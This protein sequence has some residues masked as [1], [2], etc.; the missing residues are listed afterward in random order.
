MNG[1]R[2]I[3][4][5]ECAAA[6]DSPIAYIFALVFLL[7]TCGIFMNQ[8][9]LTSLIQMD[10]YFDLL[11]Y[12]III[13]VP[14]LSMRSWAEDRKHNTYELLVT[15]PLRSQALILGKFFSS[16]FVYAVV[17]LGS[18]PIVLML[19]MLGSPDGGKIA[20]SYGGALLFGG[21]V[22]A[23]GQFI[24]VLTKDQIVAYLLT[25]MAAA[26]FFLSGHSLLTG[27]LDGLSSRWQIGT[28]IHDYFSLLPHYEAF[29]RGVVDL[30]SVAYLLLLTVSFLYLN[31]AVIEKHKQ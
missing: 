15:L 1:T 21:F 17:L 16:L 3:F 2:V 5:R 13:F 30:G 8:F 20:A 12:A 28:F 27:V 31:Y 18:L 14:A 24:S 11:P 7:L 9:F 6:F 4:K 19:C 29:T 10:A 22:L 23:G 26:V 25:S